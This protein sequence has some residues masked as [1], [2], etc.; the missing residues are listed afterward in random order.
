MASFHSPASGAKYLTLAFFAEAVADALI[1]FVD[2]GKED[3]LNERID[4][5]LTSLRAIS[6]EGPDA[7]VDKYPV[8]HYEQVRTWDDVIQRQGSENVLHLLEDIR[9]R[10][11]TPEDLKGKAEEAIEFFSGLE[12]QALRN[13][14][15]PERTLPRGLRELCR[16]L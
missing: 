4:D 14:D 13:F 10:K 12:A 2:D 6:G 9:T 11:G 15:R 8:G 7:D 1:S 5:A 16:A 3:Q